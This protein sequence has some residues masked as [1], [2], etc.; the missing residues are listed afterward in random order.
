MR[1]TSETS[2]MRDF[3]LLASGAR[4]CVGNRN[5]NLLQGTS[6]N[7]FIKKTNYKN[8]K[9]LELSNPCKQVCSSRAMYQCSTNSIITQYINFS[10][11][12][13]RLT[14]QSY[15]EALKAWEYEKCYTRYMP[16]TRAVNLISRVG[17]RERGLVR[18]SSS[19]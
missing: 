11:D 1:K 16:R 17:E 4:A 7:M 3:F 14:L 19:N 10:Y 5:V 6:K 8:N 12:F 13:C 9:L 15:I 18:H 2:A